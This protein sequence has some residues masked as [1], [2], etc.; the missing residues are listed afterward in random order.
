MWKQKE[1]KLYFAINCG[2]KKK[3]TIDCGNK[4]R[5]KTRDGQ[6]MEMRVKMKG[7]LINGLKKLFF[8]K[9]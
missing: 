7:F 3:K 8:Y 9:F 4:K 5:K 2:N 6:G 1:K